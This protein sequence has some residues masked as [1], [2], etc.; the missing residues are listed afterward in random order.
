MNADNA[1]FRLGPAASGGPA[2]ICLHGLMGTPYEVRGPAEALVR[3]GFRCVGPLLPGH[4]GSGR[5]LA[6]TPRSVW[7]EH[8][9]ATHDA[10]VKDHSRVYALGLS[11]GGLLALLLAARRPLAGLVVLAAP[12]ELRSPLRLVVPWLARVLPYL[13]R[14]PAIRDPVARRRHP[15]NRTLPLRAVAQL[16]ALQAELRE[17][18]GGVRAPLQLIYSQ[19]DP[20]VDPRNADLIERGV[21]SSE[22][23]VHRLGRSGHVITVDLERD[24]VTR[25][26]VEF[27]CKLE[28][29][30]SPVDAA[31]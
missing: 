4:G 13:P 9:L 18:L 2:V 31:T 29:R 3:E 26:V 14:R 21:G 22:R 30:R 24:R 28:A 25:H 11:L 7:V 16:L 19:L 10:L 1:P 6:R 12:L 15:G 5:Q 17:E 20:L 27:L 23:E 8:V